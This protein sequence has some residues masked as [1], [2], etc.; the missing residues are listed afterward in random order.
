MNKYRLRVFPG[1]SIYVDYVISQ[2]Y[3]ID[4]FR[5]NFYSFVDDDRIIIASYPSAV[6]I[7]ESVE[8]DIPS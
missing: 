4:D 6:V 1:N 3:Y 2:H 8:Y 7:I 5:I